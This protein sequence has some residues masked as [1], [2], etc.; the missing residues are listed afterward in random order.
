M[1]REAYQ[2][3]AEVEEQLLPSTFLGGRV[4]EFG[5]RDVNGSVRNLFPSFDYHGID[6]RA[7]PGVNEV[8]DARSYQGRGEY[9]VVV[10]C[11]ML[12]HCHDWWQV[13]QSAYL[14]LKEGGYFIV[15]CA[16]PDRAPHSCDGRK[17]IPRGEYYCGV[18]LDTLNQFL[19]NDNGW[20]LVRIEYHPERGDLYAVAR[21][22]N[23]ESDSSENDVGLP[24]S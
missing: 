11:E 24:S 10:C 6:M 21:K 15:T 23:A 3:V 19:S 12:E 4:L 9:N 22:I 5:S 20:E 8:A 14:A 18:S 2:F 7:G 17:V 16:G 1:H 13:I